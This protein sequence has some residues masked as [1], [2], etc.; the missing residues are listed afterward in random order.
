MSKVISSHNLCRL[1]FIINELRKSV[2]CARISYEAY[3]EN[4]ES[5]EYEIILDDS[6]KMLEGCVEKLRAFDSCVRLETDYT[7]N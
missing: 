3:I 4:P 5:N 7:D 2:C 6:I 1:D